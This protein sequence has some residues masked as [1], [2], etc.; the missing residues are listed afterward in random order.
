M[1]PQLT[2]TDILPRAARLAPAA[3]VATRR[4]G[5]E[6]VRHS[7]EA[8]YERVCQLAHGLDDLGVGADARVG[9]LATNH[10][11]HLELYFG[12]PCSGRSIHTVNSR[13]PDEHLESVVADAEDAV[14]FVDPAFLDRVESH[15]PALET[16]EQYVVLD[17]A[18]PETELEPVRSYESLL[19][20]Q[21]T[22]YDWPSVE[23]GRECGL[24][25]TSGTTG[26]PKGVQHTHEALTLACNMMLQ[27]DTVGLGESDVVF[28]IVPMYH[29]YAWGYPYAAT[30]AGSGLVLAGSATDAD[31]LGRIIDAEG[32]TIAAAVPTIWLDV[33]DAL[34]S[35][36]SPLAGLER[37]Q[38][39]GSAVPESLLRR[40]DERFGVEMIQA[41]GMTETAPFATISRLSPTRKRAC[42]AAEQYRIRA[43]AGRPVPGISVRVRDGGDDVPRDGETAGELQVRGAWV[44][45]SYH[46]R[47]AAD[48]ESF[49]DDGWLKT[50][51]VATWDAY[52]YVDIVDRKKDVI[53][54]GGE[55]I[56]SIDLESELMG[57]DGVSEAAVVAVDHDTWQERPFGFVVADGSVDADDL[58]THL[59]ERFPNWWLPDGYAFVE[60]LPKTSTGKFDKGRL[61]A[62]LRQ[63]GSGSDAPSAGAPTDR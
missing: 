55:W 54:S 5:G 42:E 13:L 57:H 9:T 20:G 58:D 41:W 31:S 44:T 46:D 61:A 22:E 3:R 19:G 47:P 38:T 39:G 50:G 12:V 62:R 27:R 28:P 2:L 48:A 52:G 37:I 53:K 25:H 30:L 40:Y 63:D 43:M 14:L 32:V 33:A 35:D 60:S 26:T 4:A 16:V 51:D 49:T 24:C 23:P 18:V 8:I 7:Y 34:S 15:A 21:P 36:P 56:S 17:S 10:H 6:W 11:R 29:G 1:D 45:D 59:R